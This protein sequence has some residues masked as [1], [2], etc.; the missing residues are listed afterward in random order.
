MRNSNQ[1]PPKYGAEGPPGGVEAWNRQRF[2]PQPQQPQQG[3]AGLGQ[4]VRGMVERQRG[5]QQGPPQG[6]MQP[7]GQVARAQW[8]GQGQGMPQGGP[9][10]G[11]PPQMPGGGQPQMPLQSQAQ[12]MQPRQGGPQMPQTGMAGL[13]AGAAKLGQMMQARAL[14]GGGRGGGQMQEQ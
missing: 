4:M 6:G 11:T 14:R 8:P 3:M 1:P 7:W 5:P 2:Q 10:Q 13:G 12:Q 9:P